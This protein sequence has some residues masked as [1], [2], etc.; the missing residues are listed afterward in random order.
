MIQCIYIDGINEDD[1]FDRLNDLIDQNGNL[2][3]TEFENG[4]SSIGFDIPDECD[5]ISNVKKSSDR[6]RIIPDSYCTSC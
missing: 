4:K 6:R 1:V 5:D 3:V 2:K